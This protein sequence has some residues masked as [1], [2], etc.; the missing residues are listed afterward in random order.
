MGVAA[1]DGFYLKTV[2]RR[3]YAKFTVEQLSCN[4]PA[5]ILS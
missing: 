3:M 2:K 4:I 5:T 1:I